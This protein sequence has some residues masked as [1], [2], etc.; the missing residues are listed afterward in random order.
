MSAAFARPGSKPAWRVLHVPTSVGG[1]PQGLS[2]HLRMLGVQSE[3][4]VLEQNYLDYA[5]DRVIWSPLDGVVTRELRRW[6]AIFEAA[7]VAD[8]INFNFGTSLAYP[9]RPRILKE[10]TLAR[11][12]A[13]W[14]FSLY[15]QS[16][17]WLELN[18]YCLAR[19]PMFVHYQGDDARQG[20]DSLARF[21]VSIAAHAEDGLL[22]QNLRSL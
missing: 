21:K 8:V 4:W 1:N 5:C 20:D 10:K 14:L 11:R 3:N 2:Q 15:T 18:L 16:L 17:Q 13:R 19:I 22:R 12:I 9:V 7:R 6:R